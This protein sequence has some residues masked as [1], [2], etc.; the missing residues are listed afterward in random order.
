VNGPDMAAAIIRINGEGVMEVDGR[1]PR[2][3][4]WGPFA[5][6]S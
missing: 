3:R 6:P 2:Q 1:G 5:P 4:D